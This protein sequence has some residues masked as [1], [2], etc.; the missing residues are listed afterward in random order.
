MCDTLLPVAV[1]GNRQGRL[2][3]LLPPPIEGATTGS[4]S[5]RLFCF[6]LATVRARQQWLVSAVLK[7][8]RTAYHPA[9]APSLSARDWVR[10][11][12]MVRQDPSR[13]NSSL[14]G[15]LVRTLFSQ[16]PHG[17]GQIGAAYHPWGHYCQK[18]LEGNH[19]TSRIQRVGLQAP[20]QRSSGSAAVKIPTGCLEAG[21]KKKKG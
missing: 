15:T 8:D 6:L 12:D 10:L 16:R 20:R 21:P 11:G 5:K 1:V 4:S 9:R 19:A 3:M 13:M 14:M 18:L 2:L 7:K 17:R